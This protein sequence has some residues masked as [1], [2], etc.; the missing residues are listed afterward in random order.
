MVRGLCKAGIAAWPWRGTNTVLECWG[1]K[2]LG[3]LK[4]LW[5]VG[6]VG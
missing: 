3:Y 6:E 4:Y 2:T 5:L 1:V